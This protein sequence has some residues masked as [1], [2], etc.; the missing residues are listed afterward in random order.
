[1]GSLD[2]MTLLF[3][4][5]WWKLHISVSFLFYSNHL[6]G[7]KVISYCGLI[8]ISLMINDVEHFLHMLIG[9]L[10]ITFGEMSIQVFCPLF[11]SI[12]SFVAFEL[13]EFFLY[14]GYKYK[15]FPVLFIELILTGYV[16]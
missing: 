7:C 1:M 8:C 15:F 12:I 9:Q 5:F 11:N 6:N 2:H 3:L 10:Y 16:S 13:Y 4:N 14:F